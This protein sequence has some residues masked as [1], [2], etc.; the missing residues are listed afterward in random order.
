MRKLDISALGW[1]S[2]VTEIHAFKHIT[3]KIFH[4]ITL[5]FKRKKRP[6]SAWYSCSATPDLTILPYL[7]IAEDNSLC[8]AAC[9]K[10][11][12]QSK[13]ETST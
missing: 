12:L 4:E 5:I 7:Y 2:D 13:V 10:S 3:R 6:I 8:L 11:F 1:E 9:L